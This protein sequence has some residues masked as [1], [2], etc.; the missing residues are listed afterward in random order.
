MTYAVYCVTNKKTSD[1]IEIGRT[2]SYD[3]AQGVVDALDA[4]GVEAWA[5]DTSDDGEGTI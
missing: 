2:D 1:F 3:A 4:L 5:R